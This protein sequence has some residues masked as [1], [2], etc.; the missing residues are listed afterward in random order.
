MPGTV[1]EP[2]EEVLA[3][4][5]KG[6]SS[7]GGPLSAD[8]I[9]ECLSGAG[10]AGA[11]DTS[12]QQCVPTPIDSLFFFAEP[13]PLGKKPLAE[14]GK[15][16]IAVGPSPTLWRN[17]TRRRSCARRIRSHRLHLRF[18]GVT[19]ALSVIFGFVKNCRGR[20]EREWHR[21]SSRTTSRPFV[22]QGFTHT[23]RTREGCSMSLAWRPN[24]TATPASSAEFPAAVNHR[25]SPS[26][27][28][29]M[30]VQGGTFINAELA[31]EYWHP[32][33]KGG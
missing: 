25:W 29:C 8:Q 13:R 20:R 31:R 5:G 4:A 11:L 28:R 15:E 33:S 16:M 30:S 10:R 14:N 21:S 32:M 2:E 12:D 27:S 22:G 1:G 9:A 17:G 23:D 24:S 19:Y 7:Q 6:G 26:G 3:A 18:S